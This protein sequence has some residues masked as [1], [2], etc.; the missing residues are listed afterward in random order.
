MGLPAA[1]RTGGAL[2]NVTSDES[3]RTV[4]IVVDAVATRS[5]ILDAPIVPTLVTLAFPTTA[6]L[7]AQTA[8]SVAEAYYVG[9]LGTAALAGVALVFPLVMLMTTMSGGGLGSGVASAVARA[10]GAG[11]KHDAD[12]VVFHAVV[13]AVMAGIAFTLGPILGGEALYRALGGRDA[14]LAAAVAYSSSMFAGAVGV[15]IVNLL[16]AALRGSGN[17]RVPALV[18]LVGALILIPASP[19]LIFGFGPIP[20]LGI[21]GAGV[22][23]AAFNVAASLAL[24]RYMASGRSGSSLSICRLERRIFADILKVGLP[25]AL[26]AVQTN[27]NVILI[28]GIVGLFGTSALAAYGI[29][30]RLDYILIPI[31]FGV[32]SAVLTMVGVNVGAGNRTRAK[33]VA[34]Q[35]ALIGVAISETIGL[36][37][38]L[39]P[40]LWIHLFTRD[41]HVTAIATSYLRVVAPAYGFLGLGFVISFAAQGAGNMLWPFVGVT[42]RLLVAAGIGWLAVAVYGAGLTTLSFAIAASL[43]IYAAVCTVAMTSRRIWGRER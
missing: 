25:T 28:T 9:R 10:I 33:H 11:R 39:F 17:V 26:S 30:S 32:S 41:P 12:A 22:S 19:A 42:V 34:W 23:F 29:A 14:T 18:T 2:T 5:A 27:L 3:T 21:V 13:L 16:S 8:V 20:R 38:G 31:L 35:G 40:G 1:R 43:A 24:L 6:V 37:V 36:V 4:P 15:W 7:L